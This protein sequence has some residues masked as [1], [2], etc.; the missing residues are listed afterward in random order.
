M[1]DQ[2]LLKLEFP[3]DDGLIYLNHAAVAPWPARTAEAVMDFA[4]ENV[5][6]GASRYASWLATEK[7]LRGQLQKLINAASIDDI[8]LVKNT[9]EG[10]SIVASG[11]AWQEGD[12][13]VSS[14][15]EFPS[16]RIPWKAQAS[17]GVAHREVNLRVDDPRNTSAY[18]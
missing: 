15:E 6:Y 4:K 5:R 3:Q 9:S 11:I 1:L 7:R 18:E 12:N 17:K 16:N 8:A 10:I 2:S 13:I 14:D